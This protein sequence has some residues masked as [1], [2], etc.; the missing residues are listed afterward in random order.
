MTIY[1]QSILNAYPYFW[2]PCWKV[3]MESYVFGWLSCTLKKIELF[4]LAILCH[5]FR[6]SL[7]FDLLCHF[8]LNFVELS[9]S[10]RRKLQ[11]CHSHPADCADRAGPK[12]CASSLARRC[13]SSLWAEVEGSICLGWRLLSPPTARGRIKRTFL[14]QRSWELMTLRLSVVARKGALWLVQ[15]LPLQDQTGQEF[16]HWL[17][18]AG[19][20]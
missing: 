8:C 12:I 10:V 15:I 5:E 6:V 14:C 11:G 13:A 7:Y 19:F 20:C 4:L 16:S 18:F 17:D 9:L 3:I 1:T 2:I